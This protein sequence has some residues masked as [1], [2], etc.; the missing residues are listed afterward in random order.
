MLHLI[1]TCIVEKECTGAEFLT[2]VDEVEENHG[3][4]EVSSKLIFTD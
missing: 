4:G 1:N 2:N 3:R